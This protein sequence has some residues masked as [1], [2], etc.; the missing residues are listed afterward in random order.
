MEMKRNEEA[1]ITTYALLNPAAMNCISLKVFLLD[2]K[3]VD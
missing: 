1:E 3:S 2:F